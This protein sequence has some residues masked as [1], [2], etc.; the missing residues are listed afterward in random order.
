MKGR[1]RPVGNITPRLH[2][3]NRLG[4]TPPATAPAAPCSGGPEQ[5]RGRKITARKFLWALGTVLEPPGRER[6]RVQEQ[7]RKDR[8]PGSSR[9]SFSRTDSRRSARVASSSL[10]SGLPCTS[11]PPLQ[12]LPLC[13]HA[14]PPLPLKP[15]DL[16]NVTLHPCPFHPARA[17]LLLCEPTELSLGPLL[18]TRCALSWL[19]AWAFV[20]SFSSVC[21]SQTASSST[22]P[23][24]RPA[25]CSPSQHLRVSFRAPTQ[26]R[27][28]LHISYVLAYCLSPMEGST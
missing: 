4:P 27:I 19:L 6:E 18:C 2:L 25:N 12:L 22:A 1:T 8:R 28:I 21:R 20:G 9:E 23:V 15:G 3:P 16:S 14:R 24:Q 11:P 17:S 26:S 13:S 10:S 5:L 7:G